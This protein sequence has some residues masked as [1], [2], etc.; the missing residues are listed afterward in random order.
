ME[1]TYTSKMRRCLQ[2]IL[3]KGHGNIEEV[4][5][6]E[7]IPVH[8]VWREHDRINAHGGCKGA[9]FPPPMPGQ[10]QANKGHNPEVGGSCD[11]VGGLWS[12]EFAA[13]DRVFRSEPMPR[14]E[15]EEL[16]DHIKEHWKTAAWLE[17]VRASSSNIPDEPRG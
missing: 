15:A 6:Q 14:H 7:G 8:E 11:R 9:S 16:Q 2:A 17:I 10:T 13:C 12:I 5:A 3:Y 1:T 4:C